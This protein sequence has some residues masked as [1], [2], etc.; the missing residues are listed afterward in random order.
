ME[1]LRGEGGCAWDRKQSFE[2]LRTY[3]VEEAYEL[4]EAITSG[5]PENI[6]E[7]SGDLLLQIVFLSSIAKEK[8]FFDINDVINNLCDKLIRRHPHVFAEENALDSDEVLRNWERIKLEEKAAGKIN[9][10]EKVESSILSGVPSGLPALLKAYRI[11]EKAAHVGFDWE[12]GNTSPIFEKI[13]EEIKEVEDAIEEKDTI[14]I[15]EEIG[16]LLFASVNLARHLG[17]NPDVALGRANAKFI[18]R[19]SEIEKLIA[20]SGR[21]WSEFSLTELDNL[22]NSAKYQVAIKRMRR[23]FCD[24]SST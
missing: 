12:K 23:Y 11:Q 22:W 4:V 15:E 20:Q 24:P 21:D 1:K 17:I 7:E 19:F 8:C 9:Q 2:T 6:K 13:Q 10:S 5:L 14:N 3:I 18:L 16:D